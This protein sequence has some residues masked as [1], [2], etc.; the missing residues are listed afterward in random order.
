MLG[1]DAP[2]FAV[3]FIGLYAAHE[4]GD[5][6]VQ[7]PHQACHKGTVGWSGRLAC[8]RHVGTLTGLKAVTLGLA[9]VVLDIHLHPVAL[10]V[11]LLVDAVSHF[12]ADRRV[13]LARLAERIGKG[14][15]YRLGAPREGHDDAP[16][17][18]TGAY[19]LDQ[20]WHVGW[21]FAA[22]LIAC[23]GVA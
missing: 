8:A 12:W 4:V 6:W 17:L 14:E 19:A 1:A 3:V 11:A 20:S 18:G 15:F 10:A 23:L 5:H 13:T 7:T 9:G 2:T 21:L 22:A 16:H